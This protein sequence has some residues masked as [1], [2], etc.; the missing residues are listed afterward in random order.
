MKTYADY[1]NKNVMVVGMAKSGISAAK[2]LIREGARVFLYDAK[3]KEAFGDN[4][5]ELLK[6]CTD[7]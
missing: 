1:K 7:L 4:V 3:P 2:L 5:A 6:D